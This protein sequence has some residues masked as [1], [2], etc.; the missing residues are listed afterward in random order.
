MTYD[1]GQSAVQLYDFV[2]D[3]FLTWSGF[4]FFFS[5]CFAGGF[6]GSP[7]HLLISVSQETFTWYVKTFKALGAVSSS[8]KQ[9]NWNPGCEQTVSEQCLLFLK[10]QYFCP[11]FSLR[12]LEKSS[13]TYWSLRKYRCEGRSCWGVILGMATPYNRQLWEAEG[14]NLNP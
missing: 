8:D 14:I 13:K 5:F 11:E 12:S 1:P 6:R 9:P 3:N 10:W 7:Y 4:T 2:I